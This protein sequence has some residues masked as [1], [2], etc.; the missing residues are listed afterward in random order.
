M[1][2]VSPT[3]FDTHGIESRLDVVAD[4][5]NQLIQ[6]QHLALLGPE[7]VIEFV[8]EDN[9]IALHIPF[10]PHDHIQRVIFNR[11]NFY[12]ERLLRQFRQMSI[13]RRDAVVFDIGAN[14]GN[15]AV[16][17]A[18]I[19]HAA[20]VTCFEP[21]NVAFTVLRKNI[22]LNGLSKRTTLVQTLLGE[23]TGKGEILRHTGRNIGA[24]AF[25]TND[26]GAFNVVSLDD[27]CTTH[28]ITNVDFMKIDVEGMQLAVLAG[29]RQLLRD[30]KPIL[31]V[32]L[33]A[34]NDEF[35]ATNSFLETFGYSATALDAN[36]Y[37][38]T[39]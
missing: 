2:E 29:A 5:L 7:R 20:H 10:A 24:T 9:L 3:L 17:F 33:L 11:R 36:N 26:D 34:A 27:Y 28:N 39:A 25:S 38:F 30:L 21:Q 15:H 19:M 13:L 8:Y 4:R 14:I 18:Q 16:Y 32:E 1:N 37:I 12:E 22:D 6:L 23:R 31:W 35:A